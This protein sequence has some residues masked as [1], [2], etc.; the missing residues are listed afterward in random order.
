[1]PKPVIALVG[2]WAAGGGHSLHVVCDMTLASKE[3]AMFKQT[4]AD[5]GSF[6]A[7]LGSAYL[8]RQVGQKVARE[9]FFL[10]EPYDAQ[11]AF[12]MG[13]VNAVIAHRDLEK[14]GLDWARKIA[15]KSP[16]SIRM[17]K[18]AF[19]AVDDGLIG[20]QIFAGE[21]TRLAYMT[22][23]AHEGRDSFLEK[24]DPD[25]SAFPYYY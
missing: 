24:R 11:R 23:E 3:H 13:T 17:L 16:T 18:Y 5:V 1:M 25:W 22:D 7:G 15:E 21:T 20:Q 9:I 4:D 2:G 8:A 12:E 6:D 19:N 10:G 14:V